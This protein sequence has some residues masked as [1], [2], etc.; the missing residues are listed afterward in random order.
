MRVSDRV[1]TAVL[2]ALHQVTGTPL[3]ELEKTL[4]SEAED[5]WPFD[6]IVLVEVL[7]L[8]EA[9]LGLTVPMDTE[10]AKSLRTVH[11]LIRRLRGL[12]EIP[13]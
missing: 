5:D 12:M 3:E 13:A 1:T 6:S 9:D 4:L 7:V 10:T 2:Q 11:G 8:V